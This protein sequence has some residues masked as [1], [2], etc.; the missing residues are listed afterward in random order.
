MGLVTG[1]WRLNEARANLRFCAV[2][3]LKD[4]SFEPRS[5]VGFDSAPQTPRCA[6]GGSGTSMR[7]AIVAPAI[8]VA[9]RHYEAR[10]PLCLV[11]SGTEKPDGS[12]VIEGVGR[13]HAVFSKHDLSSPDRPA[14]L[15]FGHL[16][17][18]DALARPVPP[19][20]AG[21][22][23]RTH[24]AFQYLLL[25]RLQRPPSGHSPIHR[26]QL[27]GVQIVTRPMN[28]RVA[29]E[30]AR[31]P[32]AARDQKSG[33]DHSKLSAPGDALRAGMARAPGSAIRAD[34]RRL[35]RK[36]RTTLW[37][38]AAGLTADHSR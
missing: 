29:A 15:L 23:P 26:S 11:C 2:L 31:S 22:G 6:W 38:V 16:Q 19:G 9:S 34:S 10:N 24:R 35:L 18:G 25:R 5:G 3:H 36:A 12:A 13:L 8:N 27:G 37:G 28:L 17:P 7:L 4:A 21:P 33:V 32:G 20:F 1:N 14:G 30:R